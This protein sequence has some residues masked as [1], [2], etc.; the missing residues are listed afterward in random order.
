[1]RS[2]L[3][4]YMTEVLEACSEEDGGELAAYIPEL[5]RADPTRLAL[6]LAT[7]DGTRYAVGDADVRFTIQSISKPFAYALALVDH[8]LDAVLERVGVEPSGEAFNEISL[9]PSSNRPLNPMINAGAITV[10]SLLDADRVAAGFAAFAG[11]DLEVDERVC[12]SELEAAD[13]NHAIA[14]MLRNHGIVDADPHAIVEGYTR[15]CSLLVD[16]ADLAVMAATLANA[17]T[18]PV[19][20]ER[21]VARWV[22]RQTLSVMT[23]CGMYDAAG[24]WFT[25]VGIPAKSGVSGGLIGALPGKGGFAALSPR[26]DR[27]GNSTRGVQIFERLSADMGMHLMEVPPAARPLRHGHESADRDDDGSRESIYE[28]QGSV[29]F[30]GMERLLVELEREDDDEREIVLDLARVHEVRDVGRRMLLEA[31]RRLGLDG[32][33]VTFVDPDDMLE[34]GDADAID[35]GDGPEA[36]V[37]REREVREHEG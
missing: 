27:H 7:P 25:T 12:A 14:Y 29:D 10:H 34:I 23:T 32:H 1:M 17:G 20:G 37:V 21:V 22:A 15:Q 24:D 30:V 36:R 9:D 5:A 8:G 33:A 19:T 28:L 13:R 16:V 18:N 35:V 3:P 2:P 6:A 11:R 31:A 4:D 26:L